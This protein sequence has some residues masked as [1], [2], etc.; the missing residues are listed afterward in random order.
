MMILVL[1]CAFAVLLTAYVLALR[2]ITSLQQALL[3]LQ[4]DRA[5]LASAWQEAGA[6]A[7]RLLPAGTALLSIEI[8]NPTQLAARESRFAG[9]LGQVTPT[10]LRKIV[11]ERMRDQLRQ[12]LPQHGVEADIRLHGLA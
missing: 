6:D 4:Q 5:S 12:D 3:Q 1:S 11:Y 9:V 7:Q 2:R 10:L 8:L